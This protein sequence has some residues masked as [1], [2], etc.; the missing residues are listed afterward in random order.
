[1]VMPSVQSCGQG[2]VCDVMTGAAGITP[3]GTALAGTTPGGNEGAP[4]VI[5]GGRQKG[6]VALRHPRPPLPTLALRRLGVALPSGEPLGD[7]ASMSFRKIRIQSGNAARPSRRSA[8]MAGP[9][10]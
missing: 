7:T 9:C 1:M 3:I 6:F 8:R 10:V 2:F 4:A 5:R